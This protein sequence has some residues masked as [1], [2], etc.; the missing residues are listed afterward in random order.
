MAHEEFA[1]RAFVLTTASANA[2]NHVCSQL[3]FLCVGLRGGRRRDEID[4]DGHATRTAVESSEP[5]LAGI[6]MPESLAC[7]LAGGAPLEQRGRLCP[8]LNDQALD[9]QPESVSMA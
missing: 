5:T 6:G 4:V 3:D 1:R 7:R 8:R 9:Q 2:T